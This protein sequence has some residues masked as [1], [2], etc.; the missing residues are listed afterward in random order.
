[1]P[2][3]HFSS[4]K[5]VTLRY[6]EDFTLNPGSNDTSVYV[7]R[8]NSIFDPNY[9]GTGH[10]PMYADFYAAIYQ[11][12]KVSMATITF[13]CTDNHIVNVATPDIVS[14]TSTG[15]SQYYAGNERAVRMFIL[16]DN[17]VADYPTKLST[18]IEEGNRNMVWR[19]A[20]QNTSS[21]MQKLRL[22]CWPH[23]QL[24]TSF[25]D[26]TLQAPTGGN[27]TTEAYFICGVDS[28]AGSNADSMD[29]QVIITYKVTFFDLKKN[30]TEN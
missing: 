4:R 28:F 8:A 2:I 23:R 9:T 16:R 26:A 19:Y 24:N 12:Y 22:R 13:I 6:V 17:E 21:A 15:A 30:Q 3:G 18:L 20:P 25:N 14:G 27:P 1:M 7:F 5:T 29:F 11:Y 10:Q